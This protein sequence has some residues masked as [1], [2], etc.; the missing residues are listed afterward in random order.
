MTIILDAIHEGAQAG[1]APAPAAPISHIGD[2]RLRLPVAGPLIGWCRPTDTT[3][4]GG[5][6]QGPPPGLTARIFAQPDDSGTDEPLCLLIAYAVGA[7]AGESLDQGTGASP[8]SAPRWV[9][10][11]LEPIVTQALLNHEPT[12]LLTFFA[13]DI[14][15]PPEHFDAQGRVQLQ[16]YSVHLPAADGRAPLTGLTGGLVLDSPS[17]ADTDKPHLVIGPAK[18]PGW[19]KHA[20]PAAS[21]DQLPGEKAG[22]AAVRQLRA[23]LE[24][25]PD[26]FTKKAAALHAS[27]E[28]ARD[29]LYAPAPATRSFEMRQARSAGD[30]RAQLKSRWG[31]EVKPGDALRLFATTCRYPGFGFERRRSEAMAADMMSRIVAANRP[32]DPAAGAAPGAEQKQQGHQ[33]GQPGRPGGRPGPEAG[34]AADALLMLGDQ[35]YADATA[36]LFD[37]SSPIEKY[38]SRYQ[39]LFASRR[40]RRL[41]A[42]LP[43]YM[44]PDDHEFNNNWCQEDM[45]QGPAGDGHYRTAVGLAHAYE[46]SHSPYG[47]RAILPPYDYYM[48]V[49]GIPVYMMDTITMR[50]VP[51]GDIV[52]DDQLAALAKWLKAIPEGRPKLICTGAVV[53]PGYARGLNGTAHDPLRCADFANWQGYQRQRKLLLDLLRDHGGAHVTLV[54]GDYHCAAEATI[55]HG[56]ALVARA[57]V[58][59]PLYA[60]MR[61]IN[62]SVRDLAPLEHF[63]GYEIECRPVQ[64]YTGSGYAEI[65]VERGNN[66]PEDWRVTTNFIYREVADP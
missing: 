5:D 60:P 46:I 32:A 47:A 63:A 11:Y 66:G 7:P 45:F 59:P 23:L 52:H 18:Q 28:A 37:S 50:R 3:P 2:F 36:G 6:T 25:Q 27:L 64:T 53:A 8:G 54:S 16:V 30:A 49:R 13:D 65:S 44:L 57:V 35:I 55:R 38:A 58:V 61:Y 19:R 10:H 39:A 51:P 20:R 1:A 4:K 43:V 9:F 33:Q 40:F 15:V 62:D 12:R 22:S 14:N 34:Y 29:A 21:S 56:G 31:E 41:A 26:L 42:G 17:Y 48:E 24:A